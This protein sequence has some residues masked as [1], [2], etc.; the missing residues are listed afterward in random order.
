M[1]SV[2]E[3]LRKNK[4][5]LN[6]DSA[7]MHVYDCRSL[8]SNLWL[9]TKIIQNGNEIITLRKF[10]LTYMKWIWNKLD[11]Y[12]C[13]VMIIN[14]WYQPLKFAE[15]VKIANKMKCA[16]LPIYHQAVTNWKTFHSLLRLWEGICAGCQNWH[17]QFTS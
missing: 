4:S 13:N 14:M 15:K 17:L 6:K 5:R 10:T 12:K 7:T 16:C 11:F 2:A 9:A 8:C 1:I 3:G